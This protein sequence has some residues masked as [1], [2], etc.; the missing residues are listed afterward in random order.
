MTRAD[1]LASGMNSYRPRIVQEPKKQLPWDSP[2]FWFGV[3][4]SISA[5]CALLWLLWSG[6]QVAAKSDWV[7]K[8]APQTQMDDVARMVREQKDRQAKTDERLE[9]ISEALEALARNSAVTAEAVR[10]AG[11]TADRTN[12]KLDGLMMSVFARS[13]PAPVAAPRPRPKPKSVAS[14]VQAREP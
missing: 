6:A 13:A 11:E 2:I 8:P 12:E 9:K 14:P 10:R 1:G 5:F 7:V 4:I 3:S